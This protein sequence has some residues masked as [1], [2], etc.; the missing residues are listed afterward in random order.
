MDKKQE[1]SKTIDDFLNGN[2]NPYAQIF[3][4]KTTEAMLACGAEDLDV[5]INQST[6]RKIMSNDT[7]KYKHPHN[8]DKNII[9]SIPNELNNPIMILNGSELSSIVLISDLTDENN[10]IN[11]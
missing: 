8:L 1:F 7:A 2:I 9:K 4:C 10:K 6:L 11:L 5:I 3:V